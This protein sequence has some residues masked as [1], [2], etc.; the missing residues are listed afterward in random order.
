MHLFGVIVLTLPVI[1]SAVFVTVTIC[2]RVAERSDRRRRAARVLQAQYRI[3]QIRADA[4]AR[5]Y[6][7]T[8]HQKSGG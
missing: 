3:S 6:E 4:T 8:R 5:M 1:G 7:V 2:A